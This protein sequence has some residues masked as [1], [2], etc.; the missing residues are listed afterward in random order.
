MRSALSLVILRL[1]DSAALAPLA[2][3]GAVALPPRKIHSAEISG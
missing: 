3:V 1:I 2:F